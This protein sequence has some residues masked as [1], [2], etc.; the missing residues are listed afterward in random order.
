M[1]LRQARQSF[2]DREWVKRGKQHTQGCCRGA[3]RILT[4]ACGGIC[5]VLPLHSLLLTPFLAR[6]RR[7]LRAERPK[8]GRGDN[9]WNRNLYFGSCLC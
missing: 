1:R 9:E 3:K 2:I 7:S 5:I 6:K 8:N 4:M